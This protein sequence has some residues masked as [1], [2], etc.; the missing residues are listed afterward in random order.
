MHIRAEEITPELEKAILFKEDKYFYY[1][2]GINPL[3]IIRALYYNVIQ[4]KRTSGASTITMQVARMMQPK[5]RTYVNK[6]AEMLRAIQLEWHYSKTQLLQMYLTLAPYGGNIEGV[7]AAAALYFD[8]APN[9]LSI[10]EIATLSII[11]NRPNSLRIGKHNAYIKKER[12]RWLERFKAAELFSEID[13]TDAQSETLAA[14]RLEAPKLAPHFAYRMKQTLPNQ[15]II[16]TTL[17]LEQQQKIEKLVRNHINY[18]Y[19]K[20][21]RNAAVMVVDNQTME[22]KAYIGSADF[23]NTED[24]GQVDGCQAVRSPGSTLKPLLY[25]VAFER[26]LLTPK[27]I[28]ADVPIA[29]AEYV[30]ENYD[31]KFNGNI[32]IETSLAQS[33]NVPAVRVLHQ[34]GHTILLDYL[35]QAGFQQIHLDENKLGLSLILGGCGV[36]LEELTSMYTGFA[37]GGKLYD[38]QWLKGTRVEERSK[39]LLSDASTYLVTEILTQV[40]RPDLPLEWYNSANLPKVAWKTGTSYGR[41]DAWSVGY[42]KNYTIGVW[43]GNFSGEGNPEISGANTAAPLLFKIFNEIDYNS[44]KDWF[45]VPDSIDYRIVCSESGFIPNHFCENTVI[46]AHIPTVSSNKLC[47]HLKEVMVNPDSTQSFCTTCKPLNGYVK[48]LFPNYVPEIRAFYEDMQV[49]YLRIP[50]HNPECE[51]LFTSGAPRITS[52][53]HELEYFI[54]PADSNALMLNCQVAADVQQVFWYVNKRFYQS[55]MAGEPVFIE[56]NEG[57]L[58]ISCTDDKGRNSDIWVKIKKVKL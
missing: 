16:T 45:K 10:A 15:A 41:R 31:G 21:I 26:G 8:K 3:A 30:P 4:G 7:K 33:L 18:L 48:A 52:P 39:D 1:H 49:N 6:I 13:I 22:V 50:P 40:S 58:E 12:N 54:D 38:L 14:T 11:P 44:P 19:R 37:K 47:Q 17:D 46:D 5:E 9:H 25:G 43:V 56:P 24:G 51:R 23:S 36:T 20:K 35:K 2:V 27:T 32:T 28:I 34:M 55:A 29:F 53:I 57:K 42:N